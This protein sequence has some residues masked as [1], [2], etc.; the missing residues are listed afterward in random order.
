MRLFPF[1]LLS[2]A[3]LCLSVIMI[4]LGIIAFRYRRGIGPPLLSISGALILIYSSL[5]IL[6]KIGTLFVPGWV[7]YFIIVLGVIIGFLSIALWRR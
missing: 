6:S 1:D 5:D 2:G 3:L 4:A 7:R